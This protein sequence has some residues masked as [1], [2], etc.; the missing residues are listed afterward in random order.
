MSLIDHAKQ[1][2]E[3]KAKKEELQAFLSEVE[4]KLQA[5]EK[6]MI[7]TLQQEGMTR[8]DVEGLGSF[9]LSVRRFYSIEN[10]QELIDYL[11]QT[12]NE[13]LLTVNH[14]T[15]QAYADELK[16]RELAKGNS[17]FMVPGTREAIKTRISLRKGK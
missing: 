4:K 8:V 12:G 9:S 2:Y 1:M 3:L 16:K 11:H 14:Q 5:V 10:R 15:L 6:E 17:E 13:D 7:D